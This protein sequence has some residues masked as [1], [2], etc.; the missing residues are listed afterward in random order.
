MFASRCA[1][2]AQPLLRGSIGS[3]AAPGAHAGRNALSSRGVATSTT[4]AADVFSRSSTFYK[5]AAAA[6]ASAVAYWFRGNAASS[7]E[8]LTSL[9][10]KEFRE[11][12]VLETEMVSPDACHV[13]FALPSPEHTF[14]TVCASLVTLSAEIDGQTVNRPYTP[15]S[16][17]DQKGYVEFVVKAYPA[18]TDGKPGG[19][20]Q[21][22]CSLKPGD[23]VGLARQCVRGSPRL[24]YECPW[25][26]IVCFNQSYC[27]L[28]SPF[29]LAVS[30]SVDLVSFCDTPYPLPLVPIHN[31]MNPKVQMKGPWKKFGYEA[32]KWKHLGM[33]AGGTGLAPMYQLIL[34]S[35]NTAGDDTK[36]TL[37]YANK[38]GA[39][40]LLKERLDKLAAQHP[41]RFNVVYSLDTPPPGW[42]GEKG[43]V[44]ADMVKEHMPA[45][46]DGTR[47]FVCGAYARVLVCSSAPVCARLDPAFSSATRFILSTRCLVS[48]WM[49]CRGTPAHTKQAALE[50]LTIILFAKHPI[51]TPFAARRAHNA[52]RLPT[53]R[54]GPPPMVNHISGGKAPD[55]KQG[56]LKGVLLACGYTAENVFKY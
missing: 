53:I 1:R 4:P 48:P 33:I 29:S 19:M 8:E 12:A 32:N 7:E 46:V 3:R 37:L 18:R 44:T 47:I 39:D 15:I 26:W 36:I 25:S 30:F 2:V 9:S 38:S 6:G 10:K 14:G 21:H 40:I 28:R 23:K 16:K 22:I 56:E 41:S 27:V 5:V 31:H 43:F 24:F 51:R 34:E 42:K 11:F 54:P 13:K 17:G 49:P 35:L 52:R 45:P 20:G 50:L 55:K